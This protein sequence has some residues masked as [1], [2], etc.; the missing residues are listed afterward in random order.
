MCFIF[1]YFADLIDRH[2]HLKRLA[3]NATGA[4]GWAGVALL[5]QLFPQLEELYLAEND[6]RD[7]PF[8]LDEEDALALSDDVISRNH[9][10]IKGV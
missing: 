3:M 7:L 10:H 4:R 8:I 6:M 1:V 9:S 5:D 2:P